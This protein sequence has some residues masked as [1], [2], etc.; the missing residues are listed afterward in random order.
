MSAQP[1]PSRRNTQR[2]RLLLGAL[3]G[4]ALLVGLWTALILLKLDVPSPRPHFEEIHGPLMVLGFFGTLI[5]LERAVALGHRIG[6]LA[7]TF[8]GLGALAL[9]AGLPL[10]IGQ[11]LLGLAG[12]GLV[13]LYVG[14]ARRQASLHLGVMAIGAI[15]W[16]ASVTAWLMGQD[17]MLLVPLLAGFLI[18]TIA[19]ERL[20][21]ARVIRVTGKARIEFVIA[22]GVFVFGVA[23]SLAASAIGV[24]I[25][26]VG[27]IALAVWLARH[28]VARRTVRQSGLTRYMA[29]CLLTGYAW[30]AV[31]GVL[32]LMFGTLTDGPAFDAMLHALF[33]GFVMGMVF[34]HA[35]VIVPAVFHAEVPYRKR[36]YLHFWLLHIS[37]LLRLIGGDLIDSRIWWQVGGILNEVALLGFLASTGMAVIEAKRISVRNY[38]NLSKQDGRSNN[39]L[40]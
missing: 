37:L 4:I 14:A 13:A 8:A 27:L 34:A 6:Y 40:A 7:P 19:G 29:V 16:V 10:V 5:A 36:F 22:V 3:G 23:L 30:L 1:I 21:L 26:G 32:W 39:V 15:A 31:G 33:L 12:V 18:L 9:A 11:S 2:M 28:D 38:E 25:A 20:E 17:V 35:P 24:R